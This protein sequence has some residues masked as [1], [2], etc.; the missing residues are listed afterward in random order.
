M[1]ALQFPGNFEDLDE[2]RKYKKQICAQ[3]PDQRVVVYDYR[4]KYPIVHSIENNKSRMAFRGTRWGYVTSSML[5]KNNQCMEYPS[6][7]KWNKTVH[8]TNDPIL[9]NVDIPINCCKFPTLWVKEAIELGTTIARVS[10][11]ISWN[12]HP[13]YSQ[14]LLKGLPL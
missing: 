2:L 14:H 7:P 12:C 8:L 11:K 6:A 9:E 3:Y 1:E 4:Y 5:G 13:D 10:S